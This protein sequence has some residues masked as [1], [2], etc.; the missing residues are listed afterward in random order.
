MD[1][2]IIKIIKNSNS[3]WSIPKCKKYVDN[4]IKIISKKYPLGLENNEYF[5]LPGFEHVTKNQPIIKFDPTE[6]TW[7]LEKT[8]KFKY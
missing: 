7:V 6:S 2:E 4:F 5:V 1:N 8:T 3:K